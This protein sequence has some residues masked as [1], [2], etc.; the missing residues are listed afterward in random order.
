MNTKSNTTLGKTFTQVVFLMAPDDE[1]RYEAMAFFPNEFWRDGDVKLYTSYMHYGQHGDCCEAFALLDC[2][3]PKAAN[4]REVEAL[5]KELEG[6]G[7]VLEVLDTKSWL[8]SKTER[9][10]ELTRNLKHMIRGKEEGETLVSIAPIQEDFLSDLFGD[11][12]ET[13]NAI[14]EVFAEEFEGMD[15]PTEFETIEVYDEEDGEEAHRGEAA[16]VAVA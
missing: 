9:T 1:G 8:A 14:K 7:Y 3:A 13:S 4:K 15:A 6:I 16:A 11:D 2:I 10:K 12:A 5:K